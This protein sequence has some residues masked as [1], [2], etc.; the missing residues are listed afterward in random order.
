MFRGSVTSAQTGSDVIWNIENFIGGSG[1]DRITASAAANQIDGGEGD[2][3]YVFKSAQ[4]ADGDVITGFSPGDKI[5]LSGIDANGCGTG[6]G[7][8]ALVSG[9]FTA[10]GQIQIT[11]E[12]RADGDVTI[13][14]GNVGGDG[15]AEFDL[16]LKGRHELTA[17]DFNL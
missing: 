6:D 3:T 10:A 8:F 16:T 5:D 14:Q 11:H 12:T 9:G 13:I 15:E 2:N 1:N 4:D 7:T 17:S